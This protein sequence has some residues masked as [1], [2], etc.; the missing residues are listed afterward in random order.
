MSAESIMV[1]DDVSENLKLLV[2]M[3]SKA[4]Y[5]VRAFPRA[6]M[7]LKAAKK[8]APDL[9]LLDITM[10]EMDGYELC[11][12]LKKEEGLRDKPVI[13]LS[14]LN[15]TKDKL[16]AFSEGGVD[17]VTKPFQF[18]E[19]KARVENHLELCRLRCQVEE[20]NEQLR[21]KVSQLKEMEKLKDDLTHMI[22]HDLRSPLMGISGGLELIRLKLQNFAPKALEKIE[23]T[24]ENST[25]GLKVLVE[26]INDLLDVK[27]LEAS[28]LPLKLEKASLAAVAREALDMLANLLDEHRVELDIRHDGEVEIDK[29]LIK[30]VISNLLSNAGKFT[31]RGEEISLRIELLEEEIVLSVKDSG[32]GIPA[33]KVGGVFDKFAQA[34]TKVNDGF[35]YSSGLGLTFCKLAVEAHGGRIGVESA[36]DEGCNFWFALAGVPR[37]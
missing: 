18:E 28:K 25:R 19:V 8:K 2:D 31:P 34:S 10:P 37:R 21:E 7:A 20:R 22:V 16:K 14:A 26:M 33:E 3:L 15:E 4:G 6:K 36:L 1:V 24:L 5:I 17:Y 32:P 23:K 11:R 30:R 35:K 12:V 13:F 27:R 29:G 9:F